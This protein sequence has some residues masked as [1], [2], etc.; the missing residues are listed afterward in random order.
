MDVDDGGSHLRPGT[1]MSHK[2]VP[3]LSQRVSFSSSAWVLDHYL[4]MSVWVSTRYRL[5]N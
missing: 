4:T 2:S 1:A 5:R 3:S